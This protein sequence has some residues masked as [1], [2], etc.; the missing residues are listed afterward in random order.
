MIIALVTILFIC[1]SSDE[2][3]ADEN[4][5]AD[6]TSTIE[7]PERIPS[8]DRWEK[9]VSFPGAIL[10]FPFTVLLK[11]VDLAMGMDFEMPFIVRLVDPLVAD[12]GS[13]GLIPKFSSRS[14]IGLKFYQKSLFNEKSRFDI[15]ATG[16]PNWLQKYRFRIRRLQIGNM[17]ARVIAQYTKMPTESFYGIGMDSDKDD[18]TYFAWEQAKAEVV[19]GRRF[20]GRLGANFIFALERNNIFGGKDDSYPST[21][22]IFHASLPGLETGVEILS[23]GL[24]FDYYSI[25]HPSRP[26]SGWI[27]NI[28]GTYSEQTNDNKYGFYDASVD[29]TRYIHL[30]YGRTLALRMAGGRVEPSADK[31]IPFYHL[32]ELGR[33]ETIRGFNRGRFVD[34]DFILGSIEYRYPLMPNYFDAFLFSD[35]GRVSADLFDDLSADNFKVTYGGGIYIWDDEEIKLTMQ[36]GKSKEQL[37]FYL[38]LN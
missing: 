25:N 3:R 2:S 18:R 15:S 23:T 5:T 29:I 6:T 31:E 27:V 36:I 30:F 37:R 8:K 38:S 26:T 21:I 33:S 17:T 9:V 34:N 14:G 7:Y 16:G 35:F 12:D 28:K 11:T 32:S 20:A 1:F 24:E 22:D 10:N 4:S 13:R 19:F